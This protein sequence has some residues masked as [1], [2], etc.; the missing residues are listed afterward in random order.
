MSPAKIW[1]D[2]DIALGTPSGDVDDG[3]AVAA[4]IRAHQRG[5]IELLGISATA[6]NTTAEAAEV[7]ARD[8]LMASGAQG[9]CPIV[10]ERDAP[11]AL[12]ELDYGA[13]V[14]ALGPLGNLAR[15]VEV[16]RELVDRVG[17][18]V[19]ATV[20]NARRSP[21][22]ARYCLN[23]RK[24]PEAARRVMRGGFRTVRVFP[25]DVVRQLRVN[26]RTLDRM[27]ATG[28]LGSYLAH[29]SRRWL[30]VSLLRYQSLSFP[31]WDLVAALDAVNRLAGATF[32]SRDRLVGFDSIAAEESFLDHI[33]PVDRSAMSD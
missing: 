5:E 33:A 28:D 24:D 32:D 15:A 8:L 16:D 11:G 12:A 25:L 17:V 13:E 1:V 4:V 29:H 22:L 30:R 19:V 9:V 2:T 18:R 27:A 21:L 6:G 7:A 3:L 10:S 14:L 23:F 26:R 20:R 31:A